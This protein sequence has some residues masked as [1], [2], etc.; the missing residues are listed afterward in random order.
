MTKKAQYVIR[1]ALRDWRS[2]TNQMVRNCLRKLRKEGCTPTSPGTNDFLAATETVEMWLRTELHDLVSEWEMKRS[3]YEP[4]FSMPP[5]RRKPVVHSKP[6]TLVERRAV[7]AKA[8]VVQWQ[9]KQKLAATKVRQYRK[10]VSYY[11][12]KG[13][14]R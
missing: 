4:L 5:A 9:R 14:I 11:T 10:K 1:N 7:A 8:K 13:V 2:K 6:L 12:K 3:N